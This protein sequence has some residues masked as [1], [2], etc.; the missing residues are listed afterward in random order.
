[1]RATR[2]ARWANSDTPSQKQ[3][4]RLA[5]RH[6][7]FGGRLQR[8]GETRPEVH[9]AAGLVGVRW[10]A[11]ALALHPGQAEIAVRDGKRDVSLVDQHGA[12]TELRAPQAI[13]S[14]TRLLPMTM[15][16]KVLDI[17]V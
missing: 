12:G 15:L 8:T 13:A 17:S 2:A 6:V 16:S 9:G 10:Y 1:M 7:G 11:G 3:G 5:Q 4:R 14:P